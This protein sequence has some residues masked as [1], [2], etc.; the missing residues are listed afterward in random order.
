MSLTALT[1]SATRAPSRHSFPDSALRRLLDASAGFPHTYLR[2]GISLRAA[3]IPRRSALPGYRPPSISSPETKKKS[4]AP[5]PSRRGLPEPFGALWCNLL[6][7]RVI[8]SSGLLSWVKDCKIADATRHTSVPS[9]TPTASK[10][11]QDAKMLIETASLS[12]EEKSLSVLSG[13]TSVQSVM[14]SYV[15]GASTTPLLYE[16]VGER[17]RLAAEQVPDREVVIFKREGVR[18]TYT[19]L[20]YDAEKLATG[21]LHLGLEKGDRVGMWGP[22]TYEWVVCQ[23]GTALAGMIMVNVNPSYQTEELKFALGKVGIK[24]LVC[25][26]NFKRSNYYGS[27]VD[28]IPELTALPE[29]QSGVHSEEFPNFAHLIIFDPEERSYRGAWRYCDVIS[30]G[31]EEDESKLAALERI[32]QPDDP[33]NIQYTSGTTGQPKGAT[34][35]H[36]NII[37]NAYFVGMRAGYHEKRTIICIPNPLYHCFGCVMGSLCAVIHHQTCV[38]PAPSFEAHAALKAVHEERCTALYGTPTMYIDMLNHPNYSDYDYSSMHSGFVAGAPCPIA[39]CQRLVTELGMK[40]LQVCYGTTETSPVS[41]MSIRRDAPEDRIK[42]VGHIMDH[43]ESCVVDRDGK[44]LPRGERGEV[45]VRGYSVMRCYWDNEEQTKNEITPDRWYHTGDIGVMNEDG[46]LAI[47]GRSKDM[48]VRGGENVYPTEIEQ[49][50]FKHPK[51]EDVQIIGVPDERFGE[52]VCAWIRLR[53]GAQITERDIQDHCKGKIAH[54]KIPK[55]VLFKK[56]DAFPRTVTGKI[57]KFI[58]REVSKKEL[59]LENIASHFSLL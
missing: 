40:D 19:E 24:A 31:T 34:L 33:V 15:N 59:G 11:E 25:P 14:K 18:K 57:Q 6:R 23:F 50:L 39:L 5:F 2:V 54:F 30:M 51:I 41:Y 28:V 55:Y 29:G 20:L 1:L 48:I 35:T 58:M 22:N 46:T 17:L 8:L 56:E 26:P 4:P 21:L 7:T 9:T 16:T 12:M 36:H 42:S 45:L 27:A 52:A 43:L 53:E 10:I 32:V 47:V 44:I 3:N 49:F 37:N 38:F 13:T